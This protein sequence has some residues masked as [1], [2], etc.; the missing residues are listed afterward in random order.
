MTG[1]RPLVAALGVAAVAAT[2]VVLLRDG[3]EPAGGT[4]PAGAAAAG[5]AGP[6]GQSA[7]P[8]AQ[9]TRPSPTGTP[10][11][12]NDPAGDPLCQARAVSDKAYRDAWERYGPKGYRSVLQAALPARLTYYQR[13]AGLVSGDAHGAYLALVNYQRSE[14]FAYQRFGW[15]P[16]APLRDPVSWPRPPVQA[17]RLVDTLMRTHCGIVP[18][19]EPAPGGWRRGGRGSNG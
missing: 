1:W 13:A 15:D 7:T 3:S 6:S 12:A 11:G 2:A 10:R 16:K 8:P 5:P 4:V 19:T 17:Y 18:T 14:I 9:P